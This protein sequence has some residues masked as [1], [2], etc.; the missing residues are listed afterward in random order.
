MK[1]FLALVVTFLMLSLNFFTPVFADSATG[2]TFTITKSSAPT[3]VSPSG[4]IAY[5]ITIRNNSSSN[6]S[7][8]VVTDTL[9]TGFTYAGNPKLT[10]VGGTQVDFTP[11]QNGQV[12][13]W[14]F[15]GDT[16]QTI[17]QDQQI[18]ISY[19]VTAS[20]STGTFTNT[21]CLTQ[22]E[23]ICTTH[24]VVVTTNPNAGIVSNIVLAIIISAVLILVGAKLINPKR[25]SFEAKVLS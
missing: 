24:D 6:A 13:T 9:P 3:T 23:N 7:P 1:K 5:S 12:L 16:L 17:P 19:Q 10:T 22:P 2:T 11:S 14:T 18:V 4:S 20:S 21:A 15:D 25:P 8:Q